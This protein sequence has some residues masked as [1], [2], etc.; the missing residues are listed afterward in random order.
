MFMAAT[1]RATSAAEGG[2]AFAGASPPAEGN[3]T[4][5]GGANDEAGNAAGDGGVDRVRSGKTSPGETVGRAGSLGSSALAGDDADALAGKSLS[6][7]RTDGCAA[8]AAAA[9]ETA[10]AVGG[11]AAVDV[12]PGAGGALSGANVVG[13]LADWVREGPGPPG[14]AKLTDARG[15]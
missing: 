15:T 2:G 1:E 7:R 12:D 4:A 6:T 9:A 5:F 14:M 11:W 13:A 8:G 3:G 10:D